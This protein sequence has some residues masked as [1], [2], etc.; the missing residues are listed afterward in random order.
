MNFLITLNPSF[1]IRGD[2]FMYCPNLTEAL[3][4]YSRNLTTWLDVTSNQFK[5]AT[6]PEYNFSFIL[7]TGVVD[8]K[9]LQDSNIAQLAQR[10]KDDI[11]ANTS[12]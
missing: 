3:I 7:N 1:S 4:L 9:E 2:A 12:D 10:P 5:K 8:F 6:T 11:F